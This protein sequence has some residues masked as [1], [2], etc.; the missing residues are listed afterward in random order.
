MSAPFADPIII[1]KRIGNVRIHTFISSYEYDNIANATHIVENER[2][3]IIDAQFLQYYALKFRAYADSLKK[4][5]E[6]LYIS[7]RHPDHWFGLYPAF[8]DI[9]IYAL[10]ETIQFL[11]QNGEASRL[12]H[13]AKLGRQAPQKALVPQHTVA[14]G[15]EII[16]GV[17]YIFDKIID[18]EID[19]ILTIKLPE[20]GVQIVQDLIYSGTHLYLTKDMGHWIEILQEMLKSD[21]EMFMPGHGVPADK[22]EVARNFEYLSAA[23]QVF[24]SGSTSYVFKN[25]L[26]QRYPGRLCP[27]IFDIYL[28]RLFDDASQF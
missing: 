18:T 14:P 2:L 21:Y 7:H 9:P 8:S 25:F 11:E 4:P 20:S 17:T 6:R 26:I 12:D 24:D 16:D 1:V 27:G 3:V 13:V 22:N 10:A 5:I 23:K 15:E 19:F 28:P